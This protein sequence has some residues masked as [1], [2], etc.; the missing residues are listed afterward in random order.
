M[1]VERA[2]EMEKPNICG[3]LCG[4]Q[5]GLS[6]H[7]DS[8]SDRGQG[9]STCAP[10]AY[11]PDGRTG[12]MIAPQSAPCLFIGPDKAAEKL[13]MDLPDDRGRNFAGSCC[14]RWTGCKPRQARGV[15]TTGELD[16]RDDCDHPRNPVGR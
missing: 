9:R 13:S 14:V 11:L 8:D 7:A 10:T 16:C 1:A 15:A 6:D 4:V 2:Q 5:A 12:P 3:D